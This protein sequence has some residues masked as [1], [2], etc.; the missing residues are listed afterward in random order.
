MLL[1]GPGVCVIVQAGVVQAAGA[2]REA[3]RGDGH[4]LA[5]PAA[6]KALLDVIPAESAALDDFDL[7]GQRCVAGVQ[8]IDES[9]P[10]EPFRQFWDH[11]WN[12][13]TCC[14]TEV[15]PRLRTE[16]MGTRD[17]YTDQ[18]WH[19]T[20]MYTE[21]LHP[22]GIEQELLIPLPAPRHRTAAGVLPWPRKAVHRR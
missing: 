7:A 11:F 1:A 3:P 15:I 4:V 13:L 16:V 5:D 2:L 17:F 12:S 10:Q 9:Y 20:G 19:S 18:Q 14:Y 6:A 21:V 22:A 8:L